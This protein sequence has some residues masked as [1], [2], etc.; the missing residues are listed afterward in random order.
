MHIIY[1]KAH[2]YLRGETIPQV[3][4]KFDFNCKIDMRVTVAEKKPVDISVVE[5]AN[6]IRPGKYY[7]DKVKTILCSAIFN[8]DYKKSNC[9][10]KL[11]PSMLIARLENQI[12]IFYEYDNNWCVVDKV[13]DVDVPNSIQSIRDGYI[14]LYVNSLKYF[15]VTFM[16]LT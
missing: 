10:V 13:E 5:Y 1:T 9:A 8:R 3:C 12:L 11:V 14:T 16:S 2:I 6:N 15:K 4:M 7:K